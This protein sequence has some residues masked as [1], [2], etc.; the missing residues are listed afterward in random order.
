[1]DFAAEA[2]QL[3][4]NPETTE[5]SNT[6]VGEASRPCEPSVD[7]LV[8]Y[9]TENTRYGADAVRD[10]ITELQ[11]KFRFLTPLAAAYMVGQQYELQPAEAFATV[12]RNFSLD[13]DGLQP[14]MNSVDLTAEVTQITDVNE[15]TRDDGSAGRVCNVILTDETGRC[16][17]TLWDD[18]TGLTDQFEVGDTVRIESG[19]SKVASDFCQSR[20]NCS[21]EVRVGDDGT[22]LQKQDGDWTTINE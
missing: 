9:I 11:N 2:S 13:I 16:V 12:Q 18:A 20:F 15:F 21:V 6:D 22:L 17:L 19:Y 3:N 1:M 8:D 4:E 10:E 5:L 7:Q 14:E